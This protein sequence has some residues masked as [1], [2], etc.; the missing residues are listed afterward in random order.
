MLESWGESAA[1]LQTFQESLRSS[2]VDLLA[3]GH[4][5]FRG[6]TLPG[7]VRELC[8]RLIEF[9]EI[10]F[11]GD[12]CL[13]GKLKMLGFQTTAYHG[14]EGFFYYRNVVYPALGFNK[15]YFRPQL[16]A[17]EQCPGAF[18]GACDDSV[19]DTA[20]RQLFLPGK[21]FV[22]MMSLAAHEPVSDEILARSYV[23]HASSPSAHSST[24][25]VNRALIMHIL[26]Q[27]QVQASGHNSPVWI[28]FAGDHNPP[29]ASE[30]QQSLVTNQVPYVLLKFK[31]EKL[32]KRII[33]NH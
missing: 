7:E 10:G 14:Y 16:K 12:G 33:K 8:G 3:F 1:D 18:K 4:T 15:T 32:E 23:R 17:L 24:Q 25:I 2:S 31:N 29:S 19:A 6:S 9:K 13:P 5:P 28:Y 11:S 27:V 30:N 21:Q 26:E 20:V 22:C